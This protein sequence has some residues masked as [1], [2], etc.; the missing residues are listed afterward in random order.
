MASEAHQTVVTGGP[1]GR[2]GPWGEEVQ[3]SRR[4]DQVVVGDLPFQGGPLVSS[5]LVVLQGGPTACLPFDLLTVQ[6]ALALAL[7]DPVVLVVPW[8]P[9]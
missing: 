2:V 5:D 4:E 3:E 1:W 6:E 7:E 8:G 9:C